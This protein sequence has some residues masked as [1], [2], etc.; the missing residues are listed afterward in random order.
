LRPLL[1]SIEDPSQAESIDS[2]QNRVFGEIVLVRPISLSV[3][4]MLAVIAAATL[5]AFLF[6]GSYTRRTLVSGQLVPDRGLVKVYPQQ[7]GIVTE[8]HVVEGQQV[9]RHQTLYVLSSERYSN[10][11]D[12]TQAAILQQLK[13]RQESLQTELETTQRLE[14]EEQRSI[15]LELAG[16]RRQLDE[17]D[18]R[19]RDERDRVRLAEATAARYE[20]LAG[21]GFV[22]REQMIAKR[23]DM[24]A[25]RAELL[26]L[27]GDHAGLMRQMS[28]RQNDL[29][30][31]PLKYHNQVSQVVQNLA[32]ARQELAEAEA[33]RSLRITAPEAGV[34]TAVLAETGQEVDTTKPLVTIVP[35]GSRLRAHLYAPSRAVG[36]IREGDVVLLR[37]QAFPFQKFGQGRG[38]VR[39]ISRNALSR[40]E[41]TDNINP[42]LVYDSNDSVY[43]ITVDLA[44][45][46]ILAYGQPESLSAGMLVDADILQERWH[47]YEWALAPLLGTYARTRSAGAGNAGFR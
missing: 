29:Y 37:Y 13:I 42:L 44:S 24:L 26:G 23:E 28:T 2:Q 46:S 11:S 5:I 41:L 7:S 18:N 38:V 14:R 6:F 17:I 4:T 47:L 20:E 35:N 27:Q 16:Y 25:R 21:T 45:Q 9:E 31:L 40:A 36:F 15:E 22:S 32:S 39:S 34:V 12:G 1:Q 43:R 10:L 19:L 3:M 33:R 8:K 30:Q